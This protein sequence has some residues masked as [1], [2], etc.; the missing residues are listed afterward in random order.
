MASRS[1]KKPKVFD[2]STI[3]HMVKSKKRV[4][5][6][7]SYN[8]SALY[9]VVS[10]IGLRHDASAEVPQTQPDAESSQETEG[11]PIGYVILCLST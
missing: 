7:P 8:R 9:S 4:K 3:I 10:G 11:F 5:I 1:R 6:K 2:D